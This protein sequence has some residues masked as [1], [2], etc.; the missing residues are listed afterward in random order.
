MNGSTLRCS[1]GSIT[2]SGLK[3][4][5]VPSPN[6]TCAAIRQG[7]SADS[8]PR[9]GPAPLSPAI[10]RLQVCSTPLPSGVTIPRPVTTTRRITPIPS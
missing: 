7:R 5:P 2:A 10:S 6:G 1:L 9:I 3:V 4:P 8:K